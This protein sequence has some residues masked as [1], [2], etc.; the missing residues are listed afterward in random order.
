MRAR[1]LLVLLVAAFVSQAE[2]CAT[3]TQS[4]I[5]QQRKVPFFR[6]LVYE[7]VPGTTLSIYLLEDDAENCYVTSGQDGGINF[8]P[9]SA[10]DKAKTPSLEQPK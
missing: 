8:A 6:L 4:Q 9:K 3:P 5:S 10:C 7:S 2:N 1:W